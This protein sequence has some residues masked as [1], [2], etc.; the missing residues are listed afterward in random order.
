M[1]RQKFLRSKGQ[2]GRYLECG[3]QEKKV[4]PW[5]NTNNLGLQRRNRSR[6]F[7]GDYW[8]QTWQDLESPRREALGMP[9]R[10]SVDYVHGDGKNYSKCGQHRLKGQRIG[11]N[12]R[13]TASW[14][15]AFIILCFSAE[16]AMWPATSHPSYQDFPL[17][18]TVPSNCE[19][20]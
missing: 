20:K 16:N 13:K 9:L 7:D 14:A 5:Q 2:K 15:R 11:L 12:T 3:L 8:L 17:W 18:G 4:C 19:I 1:R 6:W 10:A